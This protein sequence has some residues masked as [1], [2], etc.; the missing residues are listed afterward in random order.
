MLLNI[1][2]K[3]FTV[4][5]KKP[6]RLWGISLLSGLLSFVFSI[7]FG[8]IIGVPLI[9]NLAISTSVTI[10]FLRGYRGESI[11][12]ADL[13]ICLKDMPTAKRVIGG[14]AWMNLWLFLF[15][16]I[17]FAASLISNICRML[18]GSFNLFLAFTYLRYMSAGAII[19]FILGTI[20]SFIFTLLAI[21]GYVF[22]VYKTYSY[23]LTPYILTLEAD[24]RPTEAIEVS[25]QRTRGFVG[26][27]FL[28]DFL[29]GLGTFLAILIIGLIFWG[30]SCIPGLRVLFVVI[31]L[32]VIAA[33]LAIVPLFTGLVQAAFYEEIMAK[34][35]NN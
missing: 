32:I 26:K 28:A 4:A 8:A 11:K 18:G 14:M 6:I 10:I 34:N 31:G 2:R 17:P 5:L 9:I 24:V 22:V 30:L 3:A 13:F 12:A 16:L 1:Y 20:L 27:M 35:N 33:I 29:I 23:R 21:A 25:K 15:G 19:N 7:L